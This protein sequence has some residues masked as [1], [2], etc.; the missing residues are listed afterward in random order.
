MSTSK[1]NTLKEKMSFFYSTKKL[2]ELRDRGVIIPDFSSVKIG[3]E[4]FINE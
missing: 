4:Q 2:K 1:K 3:R